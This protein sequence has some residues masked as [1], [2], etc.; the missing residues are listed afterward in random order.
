MTSFC[1]LPWLSRLLCREVIPGDDRSS[2]NL[3]GRVRSIALRSQRSVSFPTISEPEKSYHV[4]VAHSGSE[5]R[6][7]QAEVRWLEVWFD[8]TLVFRDYARFWGRGYSGWS[9]HTYGAS[10]RHFSA[11]RQTYSDRRPPVTMYVMEVWYEGKIAP[12]KR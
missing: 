10:Q 6:R 1:A 2:E 8:R 3:A 5:R 11:P 12:E 4:T 7:K 9:Q